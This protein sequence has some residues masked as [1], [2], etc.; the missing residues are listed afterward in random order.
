MFQCNE[1]IRE[2]TG[3]DSNATE[4][5]SY[6]DPETNVTRVFKV[7]KVSCGED[8]IW[9]L[10]NDE[11]WP[12]CEY[13]DSAE[14]S[15]QQDLNNSLPAGFKL[16]DSA[17]SSVLNNQSLDFVCN[18]TGH[19]AVL[20]SGIRVTEFSV[21]CGTE[22]KFESDQW[23]VR[24]EEFSNCVAASFPQPS[25][26]QTGDLSLVAGQLSVNVSDFLQ[27]ECPDGQVTAEGLI[28]KLQCS[29]PDTFESK[30]WPDCR[31]LATCLSGDGPEPP[32]SHGLV[33][34]YSNTTVTPTFTDTKLTPH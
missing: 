33:C 3:G 15:V 10:P 14:C 2:I 9:T 18:E 24:C 1:T 6:K 20:S 27:L 28:V 32:A 17:V 23:P 21:Q 22:G 16:K 29:S 13:L 25:L 31:P 26:N 5:I 8:G 34:S 4:T 7:F 30:V 12:T 11:D 19:A